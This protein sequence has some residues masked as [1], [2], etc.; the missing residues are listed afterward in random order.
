[1]TS[2]RRGEILGCL[3]LFWVVSSYGSRAGRAGAEKGNVWAAEVETYLNF[4]GVPFHPKI[5]QINWKVP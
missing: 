5:C 1:M 4:S 2:L 3:K